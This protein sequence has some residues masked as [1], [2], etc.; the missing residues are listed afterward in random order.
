MQTAFF[1]LINKLNDAHTTHSKPYPYYSYYAL[2]PISL[3]S[4]ERHNRQVIQLREVDSAEA[5]TY[6]TLYPSTPVDFDVAGWDVLSI[7]GVP[8][9]DALSSFADGVGLLK[10]AGG[11]FNLAVSG[12]KTGTHI[13]P[14][15]LPRHEFDVSM[16][17][18]AGLCSGPW[19]RLT[20]PCNAA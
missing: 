14:L 7:D 6:R 9:I 1:S 17:G 3:M 10:D 4:L 15:V 20:C 19:A 12:Y 11:R 16:Q 2:Q 18:V 5:E 8:A 13:P